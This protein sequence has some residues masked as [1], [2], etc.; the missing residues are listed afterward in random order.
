MVLVPVSTAALPGRSIFNSAQTHNQLRFRFFDSDL[1]LLLT[2]AVIAYGVSLALVLFAFLRDKR[3]SAAFLSFGMARTRLFVNRAVVALVC[4]VLG[5]GIPFVASLALNVAALG[6]YVGELHEFGYV[7]CGYLTLGLLA[8]A[9]ACVAAVGAGTLIEALLFAAALIGS[10]SVAA[11]GLDALTAGLLVGSPFG[12]LP[13]GLTEPVLPSLLTRSSAFNPALFFHDLGAE[14]QIFAILHPVYEPLFGSWVPL[15]GWTLVSGVVCTGAALMLRVRPG[16]QAQM[17]GGNTPLCFFTVTVVAFLI[18]SALFAVLAHRGAVPA[19]GAAGAGFILTAAL[20]VRGLFKGGLRPLRSFVVLAGDALLL[21]CVVAVIATGGLGFSA[22]VPA[23]SEVQSVE[24]SSVGTPAYLAVP[25]TGTT[26]GSAYYYHAAYR[27]TEPSD[28][29]LITRAHTAL[30]ASATLPLALRADDFSQTALPYDVVLRYTLADGTEAVRY[31]P[32]ARISDLEGLLALDDSV[33]GEALATAAITGDTTSL[34]D[35]DREALASSNVALAYRTGAVFVT[36][37]NYN[38]VSEL[39]LGDAARASLL[40]A[41]AADV[42][43]QDVQT[44]YTQPAQP[45]AV[46]MFTNSPA[47][48]KAALGF[49]FSNAVVPVTPD[50]TQTLAWFEN[51]ELSRQLGTGVDPALIE[52]LRWLPDNPYAS[53]ASAAMPQSRCFMAYRSAEDGRFWTSAD[54]GSIPV[55]ADAVQI[56]HVA[57]KLRTSCFMGGG[58]LVE[59][60]LRGIDAWVY[61]YLPTQDAPAFMTGGAGGAVG[62]AGGAVGVG[63][64]GGAVGV[65]GAGGVVGVGGV[66]SGAGSA[67]GAVDDMTI[68]DNESK[69]M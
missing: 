41:V 49:S 27:F 33:R 21:S 45:L 47:T 13:S 67:G 66:G 17:A 42:A 53:V 7:L 12:V 2:L 19:L 22:R 10:V 25:L 11:F 55:L 59:A 3:A 28:I 43:A 31:Y 39:S 15:V 4:L 8:F 18:F 64:A 38:A 62:D 34:T 26:A 24:V 5:I 9:L 40:G 32:Q 1:S 51:N 36:D 57:P 37:A 16:E 6:W 44:R 29:E 20:L 56:A 68:T 69:G 23:V 65:G 50:F 30:I 58:Y 63:A 14:H 60:K 46:L 52:Q 48:D 61:Y 35:A 54:F